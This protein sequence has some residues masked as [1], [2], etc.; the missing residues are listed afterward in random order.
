M[1]VIKIFECNTYKIDVKFVEEARN[2]IGN[3]LHRFLMANRHMTL[4]ERQILKE[5]EYCKKFLR[6]NDDV[7]VTKA[8]KGQVT[9]VMDKNVYVN[10]I[11]ELLSDKTTYRIIKKD[12][13][14]RKND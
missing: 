10:Q 3:S 1:E 8:D 14:K 13:I 12:P 9:V 5:F 2:I 6:Q 4:I 11:K 7:F